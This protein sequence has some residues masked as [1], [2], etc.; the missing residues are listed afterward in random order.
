[1]PLSGAARQLSPQRG[2]QAATTET[3]GQ[4]R[5][6]LRVQMEKRADEFVRPLRVRRR[7]EKR[8]DRVVRPYGCRGRSEKRADRVVRPYGCGEDRRSGRT[9]SSALRVRW[10]IGEAGGQGRPPLRVRWEI[11]EAGGQGASAPTG[12]AENRRNGRQSAFRC[13]GLFFDFVPITFGGLFG[14]I[15]AVGCD[16]LDP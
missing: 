11:G 2:S 8:A 13:G 5:P 4:S 15:V 10:E 12:A 3:G 9:E 7:S 6:P 16:V 1:M 14:L